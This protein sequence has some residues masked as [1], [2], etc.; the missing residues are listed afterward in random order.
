MPPILKAA[1][2]IFMTELYYFAMETPGALSISC[3]GA[4]QQPIAFF[5]LSIFILPPDMIITTR[6]PESLSLIL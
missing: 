3:F 2:L 6:L 1:P 4:N 5:R